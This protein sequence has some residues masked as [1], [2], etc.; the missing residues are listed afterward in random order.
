MI[1][2]LD[3]L[4]EN[5][6]NPITGHEYDNSWMILILTDSHDYQQMCGNSNGCAYTIKISR[7]QCKDWK[8]AVCDFIGFSEANDKNALLIGLESQVCTPKIFAEQ[9]DKKFRVV[10]RHYSYTN[11]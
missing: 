1:Y 2:R 5:K 11:K 6:I 7:N 10:S 4:S 9:S 3:G 8:M